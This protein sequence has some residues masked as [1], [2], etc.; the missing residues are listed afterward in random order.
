MTSGASA[1]NSFSDAVGIGG[2]PMDVEANIAP[3][4]PIRLGQSLL[5]RTDPGLKFGV[6]RGRRQNHA[7]ASNPI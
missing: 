1:A 7:D 4:R 6:I 5:E 3:Y 2:S